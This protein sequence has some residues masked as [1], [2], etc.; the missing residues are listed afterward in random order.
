MFAIWSWKCSVIHFIHKYSPPASHIQLQCSEVLF[1]CGS[2]GGCCFWLSVF[3]SVFW[4]EGLLCQLTFFWKCW[5]H[6]RVSSWKVAIRIRVSIDP[7]YTGLVTRG[8][9]RGCSSGWDSVFHMR[10]GTIKI[11]PC[12]KDF[13]ALHR[14]WWRPFIS[15]IL[16]TETYNNPQFIK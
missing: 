2:L 8:D 7:Q 15:E 6:D 4:G 14:Q 1:G 3:F 10:S 16:L 5:W 11:P 9:D 13:A 12:S